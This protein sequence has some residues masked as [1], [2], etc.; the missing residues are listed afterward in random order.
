MDGVQFNTDPPTHHI[1]QESNDI[2]HLIRKKA[3][4]E[5]NE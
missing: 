5:K 4:I 2:N 3:S 1:T